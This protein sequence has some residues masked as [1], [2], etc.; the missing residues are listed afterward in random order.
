MRWTAGRDWGQEE[1]GT[2]EDE[3]AGW[4]HRLN[5]HE[6]GWTPG[7]GAGQGGLECCNSWGCKKLDTTEWLNWTELNEVDE[8]R[9]YYT[10]W[11]KSEREIEILYTNALEKVMAL[12]SST[13]AWK[14]P[15]TEEPGMLQSMGSLRVE[16]DL[17]TSISLFTFL[18]WRRQWQPT[19]VFLPRES[20]GWG[21]LVGHTQN[22]T[23]LKWHSNSSILM[24]IYGI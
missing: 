14:I 3:I 7:V 6:F 5:A 12:H 15:G 18:H 2:T 13:L 11:S 23:R 19:P 21:S 17:L 10:E 22:R 1:K 20:Q 9:A 16:H 8:P 4:H 24:H